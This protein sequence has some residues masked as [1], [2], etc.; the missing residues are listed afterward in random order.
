ML[1]YQI[2]DLSFDSMG[3]SIRWSKRFQCPMIILEFTIFFFLKGTTLV[4]QCLV[5]WDML[6]CNSSTFL[7]KILWKISRDL[8]QLQ[9]CLI[10]WISLETKIPR[11]LMVVGVYIILVTL[12]MSGYLNIICP[13]LLYY[14]AFFVRWRL[15]LGSN[16]FEFC[17]T[18]SN[19]VRTSCLVKIPLRPSHIR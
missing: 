10:L 12:R 2:V 15:H 9:I 16:S 17:C 13:F 14:H 4:C 18:V 8:S 3:Q 11:K 1:I 19:V 6:F 5:Q 7:N